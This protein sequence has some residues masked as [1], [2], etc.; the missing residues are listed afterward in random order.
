MI[1]KIIRTNEMEQYLYPDGITNLDQ[2]MEEV[3]LKNDGFV[4]MEY[5]NNDA[6]TNPFFVHED[7]KTM[8]VNF[9]NLTTLEEDEV[10]LL[11]DAEFEE[12][13]APFADEICEHCIFD[14]N[15]ETGCDRILRKRDKINIIED[16]CFLFADEREFDED[17]IPEF[18]AP[19]DH[20]KG[21]IFQFKRK[22]ED[23]D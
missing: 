4:K 3:V 14:G 16:S 18:P 2:F 7:I 21:K 13:L 19:M 9:R 11:S 17:E 20:D 23:D 6:D 8:Y 1:K 22:D 12:Q 15:P 5:L 10:M